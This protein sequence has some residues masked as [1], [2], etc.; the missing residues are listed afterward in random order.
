MVAILWLLAGL[1]IIGIVSLV[2]AIVLRALLGVSRERGKSPGHDLREAEQ[3][4]RNPKV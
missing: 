3:L 1:A 4:I 2:G